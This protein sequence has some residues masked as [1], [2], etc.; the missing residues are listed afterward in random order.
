MY[1]F[2]FFDILESKLEHL[3]F[4]NLMIYLKVKRDILLASE[5]NF[6]S[7]LNLTMCLYSSTFYEMYSA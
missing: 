2:H 3:L 1:S 7:F 5:T 6:Y 4:K